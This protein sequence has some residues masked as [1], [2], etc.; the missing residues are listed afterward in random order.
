MKLKTL[1]KTGIVG[2]TALIA[3]VALIGVV[4]LGLFIWGQQPTQFTIA[5]TG[6]SGLAFNGT[7]KTDTGIVMPVTGVVPATYVVDGRSVGCLF[8]KQA[9]GPLSVC[10]KMGY[11]NGT[12]AAT[13]SETGK[14]VCAN[15]SLHKANCYTF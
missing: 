1:I 10:V 14:G 12:C 15:L 2:F 9:K 4:G 13:T 11:L 7:I 8:E 6:Q 3:L 5:V